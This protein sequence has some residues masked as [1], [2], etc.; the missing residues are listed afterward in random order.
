M[1]K[2]SRFAI[3]AT[4]LAAILATALALLS[5]TARESPVRTGGQ[6][7]GSPESAGESKGLDPRS[8]FES[9]GLLGGM[10]A[11]PE[12]SIVLIAAAGIPEAGAALSLG[13][14]LSTAAIAR[15][16]GSD[17]EIVLASGARAQLPGPA[18][19][20][21]A[22]G[23]RIAVACAEAGA[24]GGSLVCFQAE[25]EGERL[26]RAWKRECSPIR[27]L[28]VAPGGRIAAADEAARLYLVD[29]SS[30][31]EIWERHLQAPAADVAYAPGLVLAAS[32][33]TLQ[34]FDES[35]GTPVWSAALTAN[36][37]SI[38]AGDGTAFVLAS[39]GSLAAF[40]LADGKGIGAATGPFDP[41][42]RPV[43]DGSLAIVGLRGGG[44]AEIDVKSGQTLKSWTWKGQASFIAADG[45][46]IFAGIY[47]RSGIGLLYADRAG[48]S[49]LSVV[50]LGSPAF[51][52]PLAVSGTRGGL[53]VLLMDGSLDLLGK[54][55]EPVVGPSALD[56][57]I[58][59]P[60][61]T[62]SAIASALGRFRPADAADPKRY[63]RFDLFLQGM[64]VDADVAFTAFRYEPATSAKRSFAAE[65]ASSDAIVAVY[66]DSGHELAASIGDL[67]SA[68]R[69]A[70]YFEK[71]KSYWIVAGRS[72]QA[73]PSQFRLIL[74]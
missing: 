20:I 46:R 67:G 27:R 9:S 50:S 2:A 16:R 30:G 25:G 74:E 68:P 72:R 36:V 29:A 22:S 69:A 10:A 62:A 63:L 13:G 7:A 48:D 42:L 45:D 19:A 33:S 61:P 54:R 37:G 6:T 70:A 21:A 23:E 53:L 18:L 26:A 56:S 49:G 38:S 60:E 1:T 43:A 58:A 71:G 52:M 66:D 14:A 35:T 65:P 17:H 11:L 34:A 39:S 5:C 55:K 59:P 64:P 12:S 4:I 24:F 51:D 28:L 44:A 41:A 31:S 40:S 57:A 73:E 3:H 47:G 32:M 8:A 15:H